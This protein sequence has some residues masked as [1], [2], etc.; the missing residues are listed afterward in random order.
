MDKQRHN[1]NLGQ[2]M[3]EMA[4]TLPLLIFIFIGLI[5]VGWAILGYMR[6][7]QAT[8]EAARF[9][10]RQD[11]AELWNKDDTKAYQ[12]VATHFGIV[13]GRPE[14]TIIIHRYRAFTGRPCEYMPCDDNCQPLELSDD[15]ALYWSYLQGI[16]RTSKFDDTE[17]LVL[18]MTQNLI[19]NCQKQLRFW[20]MCLNS[21]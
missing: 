6:L 4:V 7:F 9:A 3:V 8:R 13:G 10:V 16:T 12:M 14:A 15:E 5:E 19:L 11:V 21:G 17:Q 1:S 20:Q 2:S 18:L